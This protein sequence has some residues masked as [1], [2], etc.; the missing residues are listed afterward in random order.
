MKFNK[1]K[2]RRL[3]SLLIINLHINNSVVHF[4]DFYQIDQVDLDINSKAHMFF[5]LVVIG[6]T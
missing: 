2:Q 5:L 1:T 6:W 4:F 3:F